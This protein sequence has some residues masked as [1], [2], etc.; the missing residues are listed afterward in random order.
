M[1]RDDTNAMVDAGNHG[2]GEE[3]TNKVKFLENSSKND[4]DSNGIGLTVLTSF[5]NVKAQT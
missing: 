1:R 2:D 4:G 5:H 3:S